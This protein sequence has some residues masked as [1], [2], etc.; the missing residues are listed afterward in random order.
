MQIGYAG[1]GY[2]RKGVSFAHGSYLPFVTRPLS[3]IFL[4][5]AVFSVAWPYIAEA[6]K[7]KKAAKAAAGES[8]VNTEDVNDD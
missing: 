5:L 1:S 6:R 3:L 2:F 8:S 7:K 4:L